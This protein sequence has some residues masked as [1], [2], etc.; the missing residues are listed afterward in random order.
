MER[1]SII[2]KREGDGYRLSVNG[3]DY[4]YGSIYDLQRHVAALIFPN[5]DTEVIEISMNY[6]ARR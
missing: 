5:A 1:Y 3:E 2:V 4:H 6:M